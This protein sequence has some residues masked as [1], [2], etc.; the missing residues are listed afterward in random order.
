[1]KRTF[2]ENDYAKLIEKTKEFFTESSSQKEI[3]L[4]LD[5]YSKTL[6]NNREK[7]LFNM[8]YDIVELLLNNLQEL[9]NRGYIKGYRNVDD[10][11]LEILPK[12][13]HN[14]LK[15]LCFNTIKPYLPSLLNHTA[16]SSCVVDTVTGIYKTPAELINLA[17]DIIARTKENVFL[18]DSLRMSQK[19]ALSNLNEKILFDNINML[20]DYFIEHSDQYVNSN[21]DEIFS[22]LKE[23][24]FSPEI[25]NE[26]IKDCFRAA[27]GDARAPSKPQNIKNGFW[28]TNIKAQFE[29]V[30]KEVLPYC[31]NEEKREQ[32]KKRRA[33]I[34]SETTF[35][36]DILE[37]YVAPPASLTTAQRARYETNRKER[38]EAHERQVLH[39]KSEEL[40][41][42]N[43][44]DLYDAVTHVY[45]YVFKDKETLGKF[46]VILYNNPSETSKIIELFTEGGIKPN[47]N[48]YDSNDILLKCV[49]YASKDIK[50]HFNAK[51]PDDSEERENMLRRLYFNGRDR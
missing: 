33:A 19:E 34:T 14:E 30:V 22:G 25:S 24:T 5:E 2:F 43:A 27:K 37:P 48:G 36:P 31:I 20:L 17:Q 3:L 47:V 39:F 21:E 29:R 51:S 40:F 32:G 38:E 10:Y 12:D 16:S 4:K 35:K 1:M 23:T 11:I 8:I 44:I 13:Y 18:R 45:N 42:K 41:Y 28:D 6:K 46:S 9:D 50:Y 26:L 15:I 49:N 7:F